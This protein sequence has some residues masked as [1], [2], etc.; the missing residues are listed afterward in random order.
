[1]ADRSATRLLCALTLL[2]SSSLASASGHQAFAQPAF[3]SV[4]PQELAVPG[5]LSNSWAD[6]DNDG[7]ADLAVSLKT[8]E[9][10]L[11]R[12]DNGRFVSVGEAMNLPTSGPE[13][14]GLAWGD[15]DADGWIDLYGGATSTSSKSRLFRNNGGKGFVEVD[16]PSALTEAGRSSRQSSWVDFDSDGDLD[17]YAANRNG[18]NALIRQDADGFRRIASGQPVS[19]ARPTVGACWFDFDRDGDLD[20]FLANQAGAT[21]ALLRNDG[22]EFVDIAP[23]LGMDRPARTKDEGSVGCAL[24]DYDNDGDLDLYVA[25]Y[26]PGAL[27]RNDGSGGFV[28]EAAN[29]GLAESL[30]AVGAA[31]GDY[32][33]DG[34]IDLFVAAYTGASGMQLPDDRLYRNLGGKGFANVLTSDS[35]LN[36]ADHGVQ[37]VD[38]D[39]DG[40]LDLSVTRGYTEKGGHFIFHNDLDEGSRQRSLSVLVLDLQG[41]FTRMGAE[42]RLLDGKGSVI[43][44]RQISTGEGYNSQSTLPAHFGLTSNG[45]VTVEVTFLGPGRRTKKVRKYVDPA[46]YRGKVLRIKE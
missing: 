2:G 15:F 6:F 43:A 22:T 35:M 7:D 14:R 25:S 9:I 32:D 46:R 37:W 30:H 27:Y 11:Y 16:G 17:L 13:L 40:A 24:A 18:P 3:T 41:R 1:M 29:L 28:D 12:N 36:A 4:Q 20:L 10:R 23:Q 8:G 44:T 19:D 33:N 39:H 34:Y 42:V 31:W 5:S 26:G 45:R 38:Y 21:D